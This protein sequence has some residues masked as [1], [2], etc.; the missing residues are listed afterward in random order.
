MGLMV[1]LDTS[2]LRV[3]AAV[4]DR[5][6]MTAAAKALNL[7]QGAVSQKVARLEAQAGARLFHRGS[8]GLK[9]TSQGERLLSKVRQM[10]QLNDEIW[11]HMTG[12]RSSGRVTLGLPVDLIGSIF[13]PIIR[14]FM[15]LYPQVELILRSGS[16]GDLRSWLAEGSVDVAILEEPADQAR[17]ECLL[18]DPLVWV[19]C[20]G[21]IAHLRTPLPISLVSESCCFRPD[22]LSALRERDCDVRLV[23]E[24][25][26]L[27]ATLAVVRMDMAISAWLASTVPADLKI[28]SPDAGLPQ[29]PSYALNVYSA[30][31][32][33]NNRAATELL[34]HIREAFSSRLIFDPAA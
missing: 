22:I 25:G 31:A 16:T 23:F 5:H 6:S 24:N 27:E 30:P 12:D 2:L 32:L 4:A 13:S 15:E 14:R 33:T 26:G 10:L 28:L 1:N 18:V 29:L 7:T 34:Q 11:S 19:G 9:L 21:G 8:K 3:F 17:P 20:P